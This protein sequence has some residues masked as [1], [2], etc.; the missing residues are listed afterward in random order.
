MDD[1]N[2]ERKLVEWIVEVKAKMNTLHNFATNRACPSCKEVILK[3]W[4]PLLEKELYEYEVRLA[5]LVD[6]S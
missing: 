2:K 6:L 1:I 5:S 3:E 4:M